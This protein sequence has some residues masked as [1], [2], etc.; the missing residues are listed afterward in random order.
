MSEGKWVARDQIRFVYE[1]GMLYIL[2]LSCSQEEDKTRGDKS[3]AHDDLAKEL[4]LNSDLFLDI[5]L[6]TG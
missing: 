1:Q 5:N 6:L 2:L 3:L 4:P